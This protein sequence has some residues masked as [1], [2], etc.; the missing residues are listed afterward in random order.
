[1]IIKY[2]RTQECNHM[3]QSEIQETWM[4]SDAIPS[5]PERDAVEG[6]SPVRPDTKPIPPALVAGATAKHNDRIARIRGDITTLRVDAIVNAANKSLLGGGGVD[7]AIHGAAGRELGGCETGCSKITDA[8][9]LPCKKVIHT[10]GPIYDDVHLERNE[11]GLCG[12]YR[13][14]LELAV[15]HGPK[16]IALRLCALFFAL[17][18]TC[19]S[20]SL[21]DREVREPNPEG[22]QPEAARAG[23]HILGTVVSGVTRLTNWPSK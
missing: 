21:T 17:S 13:S 3:L 20:Q 8:W 18:K 22:Y 14:S 7:G 23:S 9:N 1:M 16:T 12:C 2:G 10:V 15:G 6:G 11:A 4:G 19:T 5:S